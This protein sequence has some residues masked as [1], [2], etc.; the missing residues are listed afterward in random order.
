MKLAFFLLCAFGA[1]SAK[2]LIKPGQ[3]HVYAYSGRILTGIPELENVFSGL[4]ID[5]KVL[6][7]AGQGRPGTNTFKVALR[8]VQFSNFNQKLNGPLPLNWRTMVTPATAPV[9]NAHKIFLES[10]VEV[11]MV[12]WEIKKVIIS[13][14]EP[15]WSVN[16]KKALIAAIKVQLPLGNEHENRISREGVP[17]GAILAVP[18]FWTVMEQGVDGVCEN[19]YQVTE[20]P[21]Y[22][23][24]YDLLDCWFTDCFSV[25]QNTVG[26]HAKGL[27]ANL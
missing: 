19:T 20:I 2:F 15:E 1:A 8:D 9:I 24:R 3:E 14:E 11:E 10:P 26:A 13:A 12:N 4:A 27:K 7:Q 5:C 16:F 21:E 18:Q 22:L 23:V 17:A 6:L 25:L